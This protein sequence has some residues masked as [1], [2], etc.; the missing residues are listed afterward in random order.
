MPILE[1]DDD[2]GPLLTRQVSHDSDRMISKRKLV[3][4]V[5]SKRVYTRSRTAHLSQNEMIGNKGS[6][7]DAIHE[8]TTSEKRCDHTPRDS[9]RSE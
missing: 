3:Q 7:D 6:A 9:W 5:S 4:A 2:S 8:L 1:K